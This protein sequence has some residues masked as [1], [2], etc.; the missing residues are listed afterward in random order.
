[1]SDAVVPRLR[2]LCGSN[3]PTII[4]V[5]LSPPSTVTTGYNR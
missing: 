3:F 2:P 1:M 5:F 4:F